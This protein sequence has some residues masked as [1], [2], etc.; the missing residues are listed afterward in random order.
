[1]ATIAK[2]RRLRYL[3]VISFVFTA[4]ILA[5]AP[6]LQAQ[7][8]DSGIWLAGSA[9]GKLPRPLNNTKGSWRAWTDGQLRFG[10][11]SSRFSQGLVRPGVGYALNNAWSLWA[12]YA[13][14]RTDQ[15]YT[16]TPSNENRIWEQVTWQRV[17]GR[18]DLS[19]RTRL[20]ERFHSA[21]SDTGVRLREMGKLMQP[22]GSRRIWLIAVFDEI[23]VNLN[24]TNFGAMSGA[25]RNRVFV[26]PGVNLSKSV[27]V[28]LG[29]MN[30]YTFNKNG[31]DRVDHICSINTFWNFS[32]AAPPEE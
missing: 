22:L 24:S 16:R 1:M 7:F 10:D 6:Q 11:D 32:R 18:T 2:R 17:A 20:E 4:V 13:Y 30:Q 14:I 8:V 29:Y 23:F 26:G 12:G 15:P 19:S 3:L 31:P 27:R 28:E 21:G 5:F 25:D 9:T